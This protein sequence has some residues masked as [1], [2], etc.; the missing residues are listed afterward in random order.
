[1]DFARGSA[2][3]DLAREL[4]DKSFAATKGQM[5]G[6]QGDYAHAV[7]TAS[8]LMHEYYA[9][10]PQEQVGF[11]QRNFKTKEQAKAFRAQAE[12]V[13]RLSPDVVGQ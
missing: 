1:M 3:Q 11:F 5:N 7:G 2:R 10:S 13:K 6:F 12:S 8:P 4:R 9:L